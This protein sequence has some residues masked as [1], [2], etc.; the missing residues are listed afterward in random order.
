MIS[1]IVLLLVLLGVST[2][3]L[4]NLKSQK[5]QS[6]LLVI[7]KQISETKTTQPTVTPSITVL[8]TTPTPSDSTTNWVNYT[9]KKYGYFLKI[10]KDMKIIA[11]NET[12]DTATERTVIQSAIYEEDQSYCE[13]GCSYPLV[14][15]WLLNIRIQKRWTS[16]FDKEF[17]K[18]SPPVKLPGILFE[19]EKLMNGIRMF[20][21]ER[22]RADLP[23]LQNTDYYADFVDNKQNW[24]RIIFTTDKSKKS[25]IKDTFYQILSSFKFVN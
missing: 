1:T 13:G 15:G 24:Y 9:N 25:T 4:Q 18:K 12:V 22:P 20:I 23:D 3:F 5:E 17:F 11:E 2:V 21:T 16:G 8:P 6:G 7:P 14:D 10:P 19:E